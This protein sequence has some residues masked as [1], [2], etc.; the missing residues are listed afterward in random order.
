VNPRTLP[1]P[2]P[3]TALRVYEP[4]QA[5]PPEQRGRWDGE[6]SRRDATERA[7]DAERREAWRRILRQP[8]HPADVPAGTQG[9]PP[10]PG[11]LREPG[12]ERVPGA[13]LV[14]GAAT[15][16]DPLARYA[17][18]LRLDG[19]LLLCPAS[20]GDGDADPDGPRRIL[21]RAWDLPL[22]WL[23]VVGMSG[24]PADGGPSTG[25]YLSAMAGARA[26][27][28]RA[29]RTMQATMAGTELAA[30]VEVVARWLEGFH[31]RSWVELDVRPVAA[32][33]GGDDG[34]DDVRF[35]LDC[36]ARGDSRGAEL[37]Y[38]RL[39]QRSRVLTDISRLS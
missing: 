13:G 20:I 32:L 7:A 38:Q 6:L 19:A 2:V 15:Q 23:M 11:Q 27:A 21:V 4:L 26:Q 22:P 33:I 14:D 35:G 12:S 16:S 1:P 25:R 10:G 28:A 5:F 31:P 30:E 34:L 36:L 9:Q 39:R 24:R 17:R 3:V 18:V 29:R 8:W 37:A